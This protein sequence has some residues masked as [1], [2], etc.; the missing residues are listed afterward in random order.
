MA[1]EKPS[2][3]YKEAI[4]RLLITVFVIGLALLLVHAIYRIAMACGCCCAARGGCVDATRRRN[5]G[6]LA[7]GVVAL[8]IIGMV[9]ACAVGGATAEEVLV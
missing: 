7:R 8:G 2:F 9:V 4:L 1:H 3:R 6:R 5:G